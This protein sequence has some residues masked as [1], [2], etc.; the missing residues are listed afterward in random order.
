MSAAKKYDLE[1]W[2]PGQEKYRE[3]TSTSICTDFQT[4]RLNIRIRR[5]NGELEYAHALNGTA[6]SSRPLIA[7]LEN[8]QQKDGSITIPEPLQKYC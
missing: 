2:L 8:Y 4:R 7:I 5:K 1:A 3:L 6:V